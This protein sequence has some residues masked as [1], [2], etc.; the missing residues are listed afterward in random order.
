MKGAENFVTDYKTFVS[1]DSGLYPKN[2][3]KIENQ[4]NKQILTRYDGNTAF[5]ANVFGD[6]EFEIGNNENNDITKICWDANIKY[7]QSGRIE[8]GISQ[9]T[10]VNASDIYSNDKQAYL[11]QCNGGTLHL[12][13]Q[14]SNYGKTVT[15][16]QIRMII[17]VENKKLLFQK[18]KPQHKVSCKKFVKILYILCVCVCVCVSV[19]ACVC[20]SRGNTNN[21]NQ[22]NKKQV[23][24]SKQNQN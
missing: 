6:F 20:K 16:D 22:N 9:N 24:E 14:N 17:D 21:K 23:I 2:K 10:D 11:Y 4:N 7:T 12:G 8:I 5:N 19:C 13:K 18:I 15:N 3:I 1:V